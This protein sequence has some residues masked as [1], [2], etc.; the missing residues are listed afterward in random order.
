MTLILSNTSGMAASTVLTFLPGAASLPGGETN[1]L[2]VN[3]VDDDGDTEVNDGCSTIGQE[4]ET[5]RCENANDDDD[6]DDAGLALTNDGCPLAGL[7]PEINNDCW[8]YINNDPLD[9]SKVNDGCPAGGSVQLESGGLCENNTN[10]DPRDDA[11]GGGQKVN[12]GCPAVGGAESGAACDDAVDSDADTKVNDGCYPFGF[13]GTEPEVNECAGSADEDLDGMP[14]DGCPALGGPPVGA[15]VGK[16]RTISSAAVGG[17]TACSTVQDRTIP[18]MSATTDNSLPS[19]ITSLP[20]GSASTEG[21]LEAFRDDGNSDG[22]P[23]HVGRYPEHL[24]K[25]LDPDRIGDINGD[26]DEFDDVSGVLENPGAS[27]TDL[28]GGVEPLRPLARY[29][30]SVK[31]ASEASLVEVLVF[32][33]GALSSFPALTGLSSSALGYPVLIV[34]NDPTAPPG[35]GEVS[36]ACTPSE[37]RIVLWGKTR[38]NPCTAATPPCS[39]SDVPCT[40]CG[41]NAAINNP[42]ANDPPTGTCLSSPTYEA[43]CVRYGNPAA[44]QHYFYVYQQS[45]R[46]YDG[47]GIE[48]SLDTCPLTSTPL[49]D[50]RVSGGPNDSDQD[51]VPGGGPAGG[52]DPASGTSNNNIDGDNAADGGQWLNTP[53]NCP[54]IVNGDQKE[55]E[56]HQPYSVAAPRG[57]SKTDGMGDACDPQPTVANG[58]FHTNWK[59]VPKCIGA[60]DTDGDGFCDSTETTLGSCSANP[61]T[62]YTGAG[63]PNCAASSTPEDVSLVRSMMLTN[64]G[65]GGTTAAPGQVGEPAQVCNDG[66]DNDLDTRFDMQDGGGGQA[67]AWTNGVL[68]ISG[69]ASIDTDG[70]GYT[71]GAEAMEYHS[72]WTSAHCG[73]AVGSGGAD[74]DGDGRVN[75]GCPPVG[76]TVETQCDESPGAANDNDGD[77]VLNDGCPPA[78]PAS[79]LGQFDPCGSAPTSAPFN[80]PVGWPADLVGT[81]FSTNKIDLTDM[82]SFFSPVS[83]WNV[84][85]TD[86]GYDRRWDLVPGPASSGGVWIGSQD[87]GS[88]INVAPP[89]LGGVTAFNGPLCPWP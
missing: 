14:N 74:N 65:S 49:Y 36:D 24:N 7:D 88:L 23:Q 60:T 41:D 33:P 70:D 53:D 61:C 40:P 16:V 4:P 89:M 21:L 66:L 30:G 82:G 10:D 83:R 59:L 57:G 27:L 77:T 1:G 80:V 72:E 56:A 75:D 81:G 6:L 20:P 64:I 13:G 11:A 35:P 39:N 42:S 69:C 71:E 25:L 78:H 2:C 5:Q 73:E 15:V 47:D 9:D 37:T 44:A 19:L 76:A 62:G 22:S 46:D 85:H 18:L 68:G 3:A 34:V 32:S 17:N 38:D 29:S 28:Y 84:N 31:A 87:L 51:R 79:G 63:C 43:N 26:G 54:L 48:N 67:F 55:S 58:H 8:D 52:C 12:D 50:P 86:A 45:Q